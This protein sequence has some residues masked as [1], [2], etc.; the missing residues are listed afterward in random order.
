MTTGA[1]YMTRKGQVTIPAAIRAA[2]DLK[3][4]DRVEFFLEGLEV[5][6]RPSQGVIARTAG[7]FRSDLPPMSAEQLRDAAADAIAAAAMERGR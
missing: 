2:L 6:L 1:S 4:G 7:I 3:E 5:R